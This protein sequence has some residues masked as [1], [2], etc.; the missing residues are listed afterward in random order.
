MYRSSIAEQHSGGS[1]DYS[2]GTCNIGRAEISRRRLA[3]HVGLIVTVLGFA[4]LVATEAPAWLRLVLFLPAATSAAGY[5]QARL[6]FCAN[7]G[8]RGVFNFGPVG[9]VQRVLDP[10][11]RARDRRRSL[12]IGLASGVVGVV[13]ALV[14]WAVPV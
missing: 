12:E 13:V 6:H 9:T 5:V 4:A 10:A 1:A 14:A 7:F 3:G 2:P 8:S 11:S